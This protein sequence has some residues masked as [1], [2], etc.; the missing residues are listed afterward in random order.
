MHFEF[1]LKN[2]K[3]QNNSFWGERSVSNKREYLT[4]LSQTLRLSHVKLPRFLSG[5]MVLYL[6]KTSQYSFEI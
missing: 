4:S 3:E 6:Y 2:Y 1:A 5:K